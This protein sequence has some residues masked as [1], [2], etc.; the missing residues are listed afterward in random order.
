MNSND[1]RE[2]AEIMHGTMAVYAKDVSKPLIR[3]YWSALERFDMGAVRK[4]FS[5]WIQNADTGQFAPKPADIIR[6]IEGSTGD[7]A[8]Q[9]WSLVNK[10]IRM[11]GHYRSV[12]FDDAIIHRVI[13]DMGGWVKLA[14]S[15][16]E[17]DLEFRGHEFVKRYRAFSLAGD[18]PEYPP[19][20]VGATEA[21]N[22][23]S[24][25]RGDEGIKMIGDLDKAVQVVKGSSQRPSLRVSRSMSLAQIVDGKVKAIES[26]RASDE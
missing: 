23:A 19:Y 15:P 26:K 25:V 5:A 14:S 1:K 18:I 4:A 20:L 3:V 7:R 8:M 24:G 22:G 9:A 6:M 21:Q 2:F 12:A 10:S 11:I 16:T 17:K 13:D